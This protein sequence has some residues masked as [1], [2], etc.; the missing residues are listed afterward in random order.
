MTTRNMKLD[1][2]KKGVS[3]PAVSNHMWITTHELELSWVSI[4]N[5]KSSKQLIN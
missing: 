3:P 1:Q 2:L 4:V 5:I